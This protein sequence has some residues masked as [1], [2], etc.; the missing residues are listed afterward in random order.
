M[1]GNPVACAVAL[2][3]IK[4][5]EENLMKN[6]TEI[7]EYLLEKFTDMQKVHRL[8]VDVRGKRLMIGVESVL[9]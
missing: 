2:E 6:A 9:D 5:L 4:L 3:T 7:G 1:A 8:T